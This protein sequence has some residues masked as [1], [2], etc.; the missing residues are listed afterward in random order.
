M[1]GAGQ[2]AGRTA[3]PAGILDRMD[4]GVGSVAGIVGGCVGAFATGVA[5]SVLPQGRLP[6]P[7]LRPLADRQRSRATLIG[8]VVSGAVSMV[9][10]TVLGSSLVTPA[11]WLC[12]L[13]GSTPSGDRRALLAGPVNNPR[14]ESISFGTALVRELGSQLLHID[15]LRLGLAGV[16][17]CPSF[18]RIRK[19]SMGVRSVTPAIPASRRTNR[20]VGTTVGSY[21]SC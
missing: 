17:R 14:T 7:T 12:G 16:G 3:A 1:A 5:L 13:L 20:S 18:R 8:A 4:L 9:L 15:R 2:E 10:G 11:Y 19:L 21:V 6:R